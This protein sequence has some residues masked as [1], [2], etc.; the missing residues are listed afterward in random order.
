MRT[1][2]TTY[3]F[4]DNKHYSIVAL[5]SA[6]LVAY[7]YIVLINRLTNVMGMWHLTSML[8]LLTPLVFL[9]IT[10]QVQNR[11]TK[12]FLLP[13]L[14]MIANMFIYS[15]S[16]VQHFLPL[17]VIVLLILLYMTANHKAQH[18]YQTLLPKKT[19]AL[20]PFGF[21]IN[22]FSTLFTYQEQSNIYKRVGYAL[23]LT[24]P[25][26]YIFTKLFMSAD[27]GFETFAKSLL[28]FKLNFWSIFG[29]VFYTLITLW[30]FLYSYSNKTAREIFKTKKS[31]DTLVVS[32]FL[33]LINILFISFLVFQL[34]YMFGGEAYLKTHNIN[35]ADYA[36][37]GFFEL[38][39][40][41][42]L[43]VSIYLF[44]M[45]RFIRVK[46]VS[47]LL[48]LLLLATIIIGVSSLMKM[49]LYQNMLG[50]TVLRYYIEWFNYFLLILLVLGII[51]AFK[52][53][54][55]AHFLNTTVLGGLLSLTLIA[56]LN[57]DSIVA[58][59]NIEKFKNTPE[60]LDKSSLFNLSIDVIPVLAKH[61]IQGDIFKENYYYN[62]V[63]S[64][65]CEKFSEY[66]FGYCR[67]KKE[68]A[69][70]ITIQKLKW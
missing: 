49:Y 21:I 65:K 26:I 33:I 27:N 11:Y 16:F 45:T 46:I 4:F 28:E 58:S 5:L 64:N 44:I 32:I 50:A 29:V 30:L 15:N 54:P 53:L 35:I 63:V 17:I 2:N 70:Y 51:F 42:G 68:Y 36:R 13:I 39:W 12:W 37:S 38:A 6:S 57:M 60:I 24:L 25:F 10:K 62:N 34:P 55:F 1:N 31:M 52:K 23:F 20:Q 8:L 22:F 47:I 56:S 40:V 61:N 41:M 67:I 7:T 14:I 48:T 18:L 59:H 9:L 66:H 69:D 3:N 43:V 19:I